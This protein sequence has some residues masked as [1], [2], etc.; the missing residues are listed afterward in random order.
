M[1]SNN[2]TAKPTWQRAALRLLT[3]GFLSLSFTA[4]SFIPANA[5]FIDPNV[6]EKLEFVAKC[7]LLLIED[8]LNGT[9][10]H[11]TIC[12]VG[13]NFYTLS[14]NGGGID[15]VNGNQRPAMDPCYWTKN[16]SSCRGNNANSEISCC[17]D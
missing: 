7:K 14:S 2:R 16:T 11:T 15:G 3:V 9:N 12:G 8:L 17:W 1:L 4:S 5:F 13:E 10:E 6:A